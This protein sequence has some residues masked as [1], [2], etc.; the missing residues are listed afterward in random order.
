MICQ[1]TKNCS[2]LNQFFVHNSRTTWLLAFFIVPLDSPWPEEHFISLFKV[3]SAWITQ[4]SKKT[5]LVLSLQWK[6][7]KVEVSTCYTY[8]NLGS[9]PP[10]VVLVIIR[11]ILYWCDKISTGHAKIIARQYGTSGVPFL[12][13]F[14]SIT[15]EL[16][17]FLRFLLYH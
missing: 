2:I 9:K 15:L 8:V 17:D 3:E 14:L 12:I 6:F 11:R 10:F 1:K 7:S 5:I 4:Y 16:L 13:S